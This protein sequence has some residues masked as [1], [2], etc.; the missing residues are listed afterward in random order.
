MHMQIILPGTIV[1]AKECGLPTTTMVH[2]V[3]E[4]RTSPPEDEAT[5]PRSS[6]P[7]NLQNFYEALQ[8]GLFH[9]VIA[10]VGMILG[11]VCST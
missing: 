11:D 3:L 7:A 5:Q 9:A 2:F 8:K 10:T 1:P 6:I 4:K